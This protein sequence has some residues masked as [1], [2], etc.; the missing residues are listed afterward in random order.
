VTFTRKAAGEIGLRVREKLLAELAGRPPPARRGLLARALADADT[1]FLGTI[2]GVADRL[3]RRWPVQARLSPSY[4]IVRDAGPLHAETFDLLLQAAEAG[5]LPEEL[6]GTACPRDRAEEAQGI[7]AA[8]LDAEVLA[9]SKE[10]PWHT[11]H[12]LDALFEGFLAH[13]DVPP[14]ETPAAPFDLDGLRA[15]VASFLDLA[16]PSRGRGRGS[17]RIRDAVDQLDRL[18]EERDP[19]VLYREIGGLASRL[20]G[21]LQM[22]RDFPGDAAGWQAFKAWK[23]DRARDGLRA[24]VLRPLHRWMGTRLVRTFPAVVAAYGKVKARHRAVDELDLLLRLRDLLRDD[25]AVRAEAQGLFDHLFVDEFQDTDPLQAEIVLYLC[26]ASPRAGDWREVAL[27]P[28]KLTLVGDPKQSIYRFRRADI[29]VYEEVRR[30]VQADPRHRVSRLTACFRSEPALLDHLNERLDRLLGTVPEGG[31]AFD[32]EAGTVANERLARWREGTRRDCVAVLPYS[33]AE[34]NTEPDRVREAEVLSAF[35]RRAAGGGPGGE[36]V[37]DPVTERPRRASYG[38]V[39]VLVHSTFHA[40]LLVTAFDRLGIPWSARGGALF[41]GDSLHR[42]FLLAL[43]AVADRDDGV[44]QAALLRAPFFALDLRDLVADRAAGR[45]APD[46]AAGGAAGGE[47]AARVRAARDLVAELRR[48]RLDRP[49]G[50]TARDLLERTGLAR[51]VALGPNGAQRLER[52]R[53][54]CAELERAAAAEGLDY[55][56]ATARLR[57]WAIEPVEL[58]PPRPVGGD[59]V[60]IVT[61]HQAKG[62]EFPI[63]AWWDGHA[64]IAPRDRATPWFVERTGSAWAMDLDGLAWEEPEGGG[65]LERE[66]RY[67]AAERRRLVYVAATRARDLLVL[68]RAGEFASGYVAD[69]LAGE[70][71]SAAVRV[72]EPWTDESRP[73]WAEGIEPPARPPPAAAAG[74]AAEVEESWLRAAAEA[75]RPRWAPRGVAAEAHRAVREGEEPARAERA[76]APGGGGAAEEGVGE[77][78]EAEEGTAG[79]RRKT[80]EGRF[81]RIFG[82]TVHSAIGHALREPS[83]GP[84]GAVARAAVATGLDAHREEAA[85]DVSRALAALGREGLRRPPGGDLRLEYPVAAARDGALLSGY[86]D[87]V[88]LRVGGGAARDGEV[89]VIDFKTDAPPRGE[90]AGTHPAYVEQVRTYGRM[91]IELGLCAEGAVRCGLLYTGDGGIRWV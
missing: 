81:G 4:R 83:L 63:V 52:L 22:R 45:E 31:A 15:A 72:W 89:V 61:I 54:L 85:E 48:R 59:A 73:A 84:A 60:Q 40:G 78:E 24:E 25:R 6:A 67:A 10:G 33:T 39:A 18:A 65:L 26:E 19:V 53:E 27:A 2:H 62:L 91:L 28:G 80:R 68:P 1:A 11:R 66:R 17:A 77:G 29:A 42:Q 70:E 69:A 56:G 30:I 88:G 7:L 36:E 14:P 32:A 35:V 55:D 57:P 64:T 5:R 21:D 46:G 82:D 41:L 75:G 37:L 47:G 50:E 58:D 51:A 79:A 86:V 74:L 44:A 76:T 12:G 49:P 71:A 20:P 16:R 43:R 3:L 8:A 87:L 90:V 38:D 23:G 34:G 13:R 9:E